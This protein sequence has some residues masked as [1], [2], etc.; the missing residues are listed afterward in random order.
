MLQNVTLCRH[1]NEQRAACL[2]VRF[3]W[4]KSVEVGTIKQG[5]CLGKPKVYWNENER[6][7][8]WRVM[9]LVHVYSDIMESTMKLGTF[10]MYQ[11]HAV[12]LSFTVESRWNL[13]NKGQTLVGFQPV[14]YRDDYSTVQVIGEPESGGNANLGKISELVSLKV[15]LQRQQF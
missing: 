8:L 13:I 6:N 7:G 14:Q 9:G 5:M 11:V 4:L 15:A 10:M 2:P 1:H 3:R 12:M